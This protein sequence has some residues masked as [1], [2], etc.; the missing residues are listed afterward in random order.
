M[1]RCRHCQAELGEQPAWCAACGA[2]QPF[3]P[4]LSHFAILG[5]PATFPQD[6][7][8]I[9]ER[10]LTLQRALHPDRFS[11][12]GPAEQRL[13]LEWSTRINE[14]LAILTDP[15]RRADYLFQQ[16]FGHSALGEEQGSLRNPVI[17]LREMERREALEDAALLQDHQALDSMRTAAEQEENQLQKR[18][19]AMFHRGAEA[20]EIAPLLQEWQ[21]LR[22]FLAEMERREEEWDLL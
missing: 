1:G 7:G 18:L 17:L 12:A 21:Y 20:S 14:A 22:K 10:A 16:R 13:S 8:Q 3:D 11:Q 5:L 15:L 19:S 2:V 6:A 4:G 9:R